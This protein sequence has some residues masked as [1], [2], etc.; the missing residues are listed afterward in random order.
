MRLSLSDNSTGIGMASSS[1]SLAFSFSFS[2]SAS[3]A[4]SDTLMAYSSSWMGWYLDPCLEP[5]SEG[6]SLLVPS[7]ITSLS[8]KT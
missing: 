7:F 4:F 3:R 8:G 5:L 6:I 2:S 1:S